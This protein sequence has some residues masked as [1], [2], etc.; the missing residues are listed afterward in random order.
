MTPRYFIRLLFTLEKM[1]NIS[2]G[3]DWRFT[4]KIYV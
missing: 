1:P 4:E 3:C 2:N